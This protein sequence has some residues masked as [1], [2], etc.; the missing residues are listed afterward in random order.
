MRQGRPAKA[1]DPLE[2][3]ARLQ[4]DELQVRQLLGDAYT[5]L[6]RPREALP[7]QIKISELAPGDPMAWVVL[8]QTYDALAGDAFDA[9][10]KAAPESAWML[11]LLADLR[12]S[13]QQY[14]SAFYLYQQAIERDPKMRGLHAGLAEVYRQTGKADW[15]AVEA[16]RE[17]ALPKADCSTAK[18]ECAVAQGK[19]RAVATVKTATAEEHF[20]RAKAASQL[21]S[22][23]FV[24]LEGLPDTAHKYELLGQVLADQERFGESAEAWRKAVALEPKNAEF[25]E[26]LAAQLYY[27]RMS[28]EAL[29]RVEALARQHPN[30]ARWSFFLGDLYVQQ[31]K[32][33]QAVPLLERARKQAPDMLPIRHALGR[34][35]MQAGEAQKAVPELE[36]ALPI[37]VDGSLHY[38]LAQ[39]Y[40]QTGRRDE[41]KAPLAQ[42]QQMQQAQQAQLQAAQQMEIT[43][44][45]P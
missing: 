34:A 19:L 18:L 5:Q 32:V 12:A 39:A 25:S 3:A 42:Y 2:K 43:A 9:L 4:P 15:A 37:D 28:E 44:P 45:A 35:Y 26:E 10:E 38:Q 21:A 8:L 33:E 20:W 31:Q 7:H 36:A 13:Q 27:A 11:R 29:P 30:E 17:A 24:K 41:A 14:P 22:Q 16:N 23:A 40:I 1:L 6:G